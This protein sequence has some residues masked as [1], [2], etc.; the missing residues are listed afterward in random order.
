[1]ERKL[2]SDKAAGRV[3]KVGKITGFLREWSE[4]GMKERCNKTDK[5]MENK[6]DS[7][8]HNPT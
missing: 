7:S 4:S 8:Q 1:M 6:A 2:S 3:M 5:D